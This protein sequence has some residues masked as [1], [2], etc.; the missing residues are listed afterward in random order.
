MNGRITALQLA[1]MRAR[2]EP[3]D[4]LDAMAAVLC[5]DRDKLEVAEIARSRSQVLFN[6][7]VQQLYEFGSNK[8]GCTSLGCSS[9]LP[10]NTIVLQYLLMRA[11]PFSVLFQVKDL[12]AA[13]GDEQHAAEVCHRG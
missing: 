3:G 7:Q 9:L 4:G 5:P 6:Q 1:A 11:Y 13:L 2:D 10:V 12:V 8:T